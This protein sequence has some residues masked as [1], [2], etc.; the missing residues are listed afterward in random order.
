M[1][2]EDKIIY[3]ILKI[4]IKVNFNNECY[5]PINQNNDRDKRRSNFPISVWI[6]NVV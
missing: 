4:K 3:I 2:I 5:D 1:F 6:I